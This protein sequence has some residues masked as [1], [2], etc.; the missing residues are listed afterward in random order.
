MRCGGE[1]GFTLME[2][3]VVMGIF[4]MVVV[5]ASDIFLLAST[6]QRKV[7]D[8][9]RIQADARFTME[10]ITREVRAG[11]IDYG[12]YEGRADPVSVP[13]RELALVDS[14]NTH[15][16]FYRSE[17]PGDCV[18]QNSAPCLVVR[19]ESGDS[20]PI[21]PRDVVVRTA[22]FYIAPATDPT[23]FTVETG[24]Y[25]TDQHPRVTVV[26]VL[27]ASAGRAA[28]RALVSFQ[29]T[30]ASRIYRR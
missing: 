5:A 12:Y 20:V 25:D 10:A 1:A 17:D 7:F 29:T 21:T 30:V 22:S 14:N 16:V 27:E 3:V 4:S 18:D 24:T 19:I 26:L 8:L 15:L 6:A 9:E 23:K 28:R 11:G 2:L 13:E